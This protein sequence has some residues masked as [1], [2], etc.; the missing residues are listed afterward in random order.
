MSEKLSSPYC[1]VSLDAAKSVLRFTRT[2]LPYVSLA[3]MLDVH[4]RVGRVF[5]RLGRDRYVLLV[6]MRCA[7][8]NHD[9]GFDAAAAQA[10]R[11]MV[12]G[13][14]RLA[15]LVNTA[16][17]ALQV[18]RH[19]REDN[20]PGDVFTDETAALEYLARLKVEPPPASGVGVVKEGPFG[21]LARL[22]S[23]K[24]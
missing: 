18:K 9:P 21:H 1:T 13:F 22:A 4:D 2:D 3:A 19:M 12:R 6:D 20:L 23:R 15:V 24:K 7:P 17:G 16:L 14:G 8:L 5:D 11:T 10:R